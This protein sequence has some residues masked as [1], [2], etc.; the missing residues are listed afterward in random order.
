MK[1]ITRNFS[2]KEK[3]IIALMLVILLIFAYSYFVD[4]PIKKDIEDQKQMQSDLQK[5]IDTASSKIMVLQQMQK[6]LDELNAGDKPTLMPPYNA[7]ERERSFL[8]NIV[9]VTG[10]YTISI[11]DC[12]RNGDQ[13]RRQFTVTFTTENYSQVVWFL[14]QITKCT[15]RC[16][17]NDA[18][19]TINRTKNESGIDEESSVSVTMTATFFETMVGGVPDE[20]LPSDTKR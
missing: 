20:A 16:V 10:D 1:G 8:A 2:G 7:S 6:E 19:C 15:Y 4:K 11:A 5:E 18:R 3:I 17:I 14:T 13:I 9:K 12:T